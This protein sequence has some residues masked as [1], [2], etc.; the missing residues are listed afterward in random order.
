MPT[1]EGGEGEQKQP[2][3]DQEGE[4]VHQAAWGSLRSLPV[5]YGD[6][7]RILL[8]FNVI[9]LLTKIC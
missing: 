2:E 5:F 7:E 9:L 3:A 8:S 1:V 6:L 4:T